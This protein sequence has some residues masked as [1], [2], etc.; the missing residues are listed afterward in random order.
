MVI[1]IIDELGVGADKA[2]G[3]T[4]V[5]I[6]PDRAMAF[7]VALQRVHLE[8]RPIHI[9]RTCRDFEQSKDV[10]EFLYMGHLNAARRPSLAEGFKPFVSKS[11]YHE[12]LYR[13]AL[14]VAKGRHIP[15]TLCLNKTN[16]VSII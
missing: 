13:V 16:Q 11:D 15:L 3:D 7:Q 2:E 12:G 1:L 9:L 5:A 10:S 14:Q 4:P 6:N 8:R